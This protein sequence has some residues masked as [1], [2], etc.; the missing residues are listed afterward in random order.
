[1][2]TVKSIKS[3]TETG[4]YAPSFERENCGFGLI[5]HMDGAKS[6]WVIEKSIE[7]LARLTHRGAI[8]ADGKTGDGCGLLIQKPD[9]FFR[10]VAQ[11]EK[12]ELSKQY[13]VGVIFLSQ[14]PEEEK[15][16]RQTIIDSLEKENLQ[17]LGWRQVPVDPSVLGKEA[18]LSMPVIEHVFVGPASDMDDATF[19]RHLYIARR[20]L[21]MMFKK[22]KTI[23]SSMSYHTYFLLLNF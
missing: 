1:M 4:I 23:T 15:F 20:S 3:L 22:N 13:G 7:S 9:S 21:F 17:F 14:H 2:S 10:S 8:S 18:S 16:A 19:E 12:I 6:H 11:E 5:S